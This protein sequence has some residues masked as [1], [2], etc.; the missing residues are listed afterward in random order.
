MTHVVEINDLGQLVHYRSVWDS[1]LKETPGASFFQTTDWLEVYWKHFGAEQKLRLF[2]VESD[3][4]PMGILPLCVRRQS[5]P[6]GTSLV[7]TFPGIH[8]TVCAGPIG[9]QPTGTLLLIMGYLRRTKRDWDWID[10]SGIGAEGQTGVIRVMR[11]MG[12]SIQEQVKDD[13]AI[14]DLGGTWDQ[15][16]INQFKTWPWREWNEVRGIAYRDAVQYIR[17]R[18]QSRVAE[19]VGPRWDLYRAC[20]DIAGGNLEESF[21]AGTRLSDQVTSDFLREI[22]AAA[23]HRGMLDLNLLWFEGRPVA[24]QYNFHHRGRLIGWQRRGSVNGFVPGTANFL[25][26]ETIRDSFARHDSCYHLGPTDVDPQGRFATRREKTYG[27]T[28][29]P[30]L[31]WK[32]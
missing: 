28:H 5:S 9:A 31:A 6:R 30:R 7:L 10:F 32:W 16:L 4:R 11:A 18:P 26:W 12:W 25:Q 20:Q 8:P 15:Y 22:Y 1:L 21:P 13:T 24:F 27:Y 14:V 19:A 23:A 3:D 29:V 17:Y 2:V